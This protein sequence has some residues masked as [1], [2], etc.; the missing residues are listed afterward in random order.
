[1]E[2]KNLIFRYFLYF[3][4]SFSLS[5]FVI[6]WFKNIS[7]E[8]VLNDYKKESLNKY[9]R[10]Y[11]E[12]IKTS[13][14]IYFNGF[15]KNKKLIS[16]L[17]KSDENKIKDELYLE[18]EPEFSYYKTLGIYDISFYTVDSKPILN[19]QDVNFDDNFNL[20]ITQKVVASKK[21]FVDIKYGD[22]NSAIVFS[23]PIIDEKL[24]LLAVVNFEF[25]FN[26]ILNKLN[27]NSDLIFEKFVSNS[28]DIEKDRLFILIPIFK[29]E[30]SKTF[31]LKSN[32]LEKNIKIE[33]LN[34]FYNFLTIFFGL[35]LALIIFLIYKAK[36]QDIKNKLLKNS[37]DELFSQVDRYVLKLDTDL[38]GKI[39]FVTKSFC[40][41]SGYSK[42]EIIGKYANI[43]RHPDM[44][45]N[46]YKNLWKELRAK[47]IWQGEVKNIDKFG[48]TYWVKTSLFPKYNDKKQHIG[49]SS[50]RTDITATKQLE[51]TNRLLKE[52]LSNRLNDLKIQDETALNSL[53]VAL[54]SKIL[55][56]FSH[57]WKK[58]IS[59]IYFELLKLE[60]IKK[61]L[62]ISK[63]EDVKNNI[64]SELRELSDMLNETKTLFSS[65]QNMSSNLFDIVKNLSN[66][67]D[68]SLLE[69]VYDF[70]ENIKINFAH[71][72][73]KNIIINILSTIVEFAKK[74]S[75]ERVIVTISLQIEENSDE[76]V[77][78]IEDNIK[79][80]RKKEFFEQF[81]NFEDENK[82]DS[83]IYLAKLLADK[84]QAIFLCNILEN[85]TSYYIKFK[86]AKIF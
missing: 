3:I 65:R 28:S 34:D 17:Q 59:K 36:N 32:L 12:L 71:N 19:F 14:F 43:L 54:M 38:D 75:L 57:Q 78:K 7:L 56:S 52:D 55:D 42:D 9:N 26:Q 27:S 48:N 11:D 69:I 83:K 5:I 39:T 76:I 63:I 13:D 64:E 24:N 21:E 61:D 2:N 6:N 8:A 53:K 46:F 72:D 22:K 44:S 23:K 67:F 10:Y 66:K 20:N 25:N 37:Y 70:D 81:L 35:S 80:I 49:Y 68:N 50:I 62:D 4:L 85:S 60:N 45:Q 1:M 73:L 41:M 40:E 77:L 30:D 33:K 16:I 86:K 29:L 51:K 84:N 74:Y 47:K 31:Y 18:F 79:D 58:P 82:F 15:I